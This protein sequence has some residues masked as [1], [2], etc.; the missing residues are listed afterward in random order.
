MKNLREEVVSNCSEFQRPNPGHPQLYRPQGCLTPRV[1]VLAQLHNC[2]FSART[3]PFSTTNYS[4]FKLRTRLHC[5]VVQWIHCITSRTCSIR[6][7]PCDIP[8]RSPSTL[9]WVSSERSSPPQSHHPKISSSLVEGGSFSPSSN[10][11]VGL[12]ARMTIGTH[13]CNQPSLS[14]VRSSTKRHD[15]QWQSWA[16]QHHVSRKRTSPPPPY[17]TKVFNICL[18]HALPPYMFSCLYHLPERYIMGVQ[19]WASQT[20]DIFSPSPPGPRFFLFGCK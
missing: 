17:P 12:L 4:W 5:A 13:Q 2:T 15:V 8:D 1:V 7:V 3:V 18:A 9:D 14:A 11:T 6:A 10:S 20:T 16:P 19:T